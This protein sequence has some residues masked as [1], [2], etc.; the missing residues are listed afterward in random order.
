MIISDGGNVMF[1]VLLS[2]LLIQIILIAVKIFDVIDWTW[3]QVFMPIIV[4]TGFYML[5][6]VWVV[7]CLGGL[8]FR[9]IKN[10]RIRK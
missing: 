4:L 1:K 2:T 9:G 3:L 5:V 7:S 6:I 10:K 8:I